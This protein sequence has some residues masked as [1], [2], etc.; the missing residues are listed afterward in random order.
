MVKLL[1]VF[2]KGS[3]YVFDIIVIIL[4]AM[5][6]AMTTCKDMIVRLDL[7]T[8]ASTQ[9][10]QIWLNSLDQTAI[11]Q[12]TRLDTPYGKKST[13]IKENTLKGAIFIC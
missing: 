4:V 7:R 10:P 12:A 3:K 13:F 5:K 9:R 11:Y 6:P 1:G 8:Q 2:H